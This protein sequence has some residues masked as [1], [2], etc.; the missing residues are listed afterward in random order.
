MTNQGTISIKIHPC[1]PMYVLN[2]LIEHRQMIIY[3]GVSALST[4]GHT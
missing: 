3:W 1:E 2:F 4:I